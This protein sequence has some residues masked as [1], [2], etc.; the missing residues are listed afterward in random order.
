MKQMFR[1]H[2]FA[3]AGFVLATVV[4]LF[5]TVRFVVSV[6]YWS[7]SAHHHETV[8]AWMTIG[9]VGKSWGL[10]PRQIDAAAGFAVPTGH[11]PQT[12]REIAEARGQTVDQ[13]IAAV[14]AAVASLRPPGGQP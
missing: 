9:Y 3:A 8:K 10:D 12:I 7:D 2:P 13:V 11:G 1:D 4:T 14:N 6:V 5:F